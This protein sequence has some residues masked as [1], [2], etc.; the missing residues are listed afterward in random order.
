VPETEVGGG[1]GSGLAICI[2]TCHDNKRTPRGEWG[3]PPGCRRSLQR[4]RA[5]ADR[6]NPHR[7]PCSARGVVKSF[8][9]AWCE[10]KVFGG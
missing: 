1:S 8:G 3:F 5:T 6:R 9:F 2:H 10:V 4:A 7:A